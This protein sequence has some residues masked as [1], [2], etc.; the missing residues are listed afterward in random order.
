MPPTLCSVDGVFSFVRTLWIIRY[1]IVARLPLDYLLDL[2]V[3]SG[4]LSASELAIVFFSVD[5][6]TTGGRCRDLKYT[7]EETSQLR[8]TDSRDNKLTDRPSAKLNEGGLRT[9][10][11]AWKANTGTRY[12]NGHRH[13]MMM[14]PAAIF[15][16]IQLAEEELIEWFHSFTC[17]L[18]FLSF[19]LK[20]TPRLLA[21]F[22]LSL[23][24]LCLACK[25]FFSTFS[26][27]VSV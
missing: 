8:V 1:A 9:V 22:P 27:P 13:R 26:S 3:I 12:N 25:C 15:K 5:T 2:V 21:S 4:P 10:L 7:G 23:T 14:A 19:S 6:F 11:S 20:K 17:S 24:L 18:F 16:P